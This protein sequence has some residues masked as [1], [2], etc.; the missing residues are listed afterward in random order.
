MSHGARIKM[1]VQHFFK[2]VFYKKKYKLKLAEEA[3]WH[4]TRYIIPR[5]RV[6]IQL[7][8]KDKQINLRQ[9][10]CFS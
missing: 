9:A 3:H 7:G 10:N 8:A 2:K 4:S 6:R 1:L 5:M